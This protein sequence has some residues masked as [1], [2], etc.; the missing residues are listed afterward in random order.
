MINN[1]TKE[2]DMK[3]FT[4]IFEC[5][6]AI[7]W[8]RVLPSGD[9]EIKNDYWYAPTKKHTMTKERFIEWINDCNKPEIV[10]G[11]LK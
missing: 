1:N 9:V 10:E 8:A 11:I 3:P 7:T 6:T 2:N 5:A 4:K